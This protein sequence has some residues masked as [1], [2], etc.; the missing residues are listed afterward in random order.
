MTTFEVEIAQTLY[1]IVTI[2]YEDDA[3][4]EATDEEI[5]EAA[6]DNVLEMSETD[7]FEEMNDHYSFAAHEE[8]QVNIMTID[9]ERYE[10]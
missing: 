4:E 8:R 7:N 6:I 10:Q 2:E 5:L 3:D 1:W 9:G